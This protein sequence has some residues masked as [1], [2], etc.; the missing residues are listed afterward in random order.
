M[1][2]HTRRQNTAAS[3]TVV[4][5]SDTVDIVGWREV[6]GLWIGG[7]GALRYLDHMGNEITLTN[8]AAG[9]FPVAVK[10]VFNTTTSATEILVLKHSA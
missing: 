6:V 8:V 5:K 9:L 4:A 3:S 7:A 1:V 2:S 10:R